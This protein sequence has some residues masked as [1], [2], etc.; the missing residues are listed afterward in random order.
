MKF[1]RVAAGGLA[2]AAALTVSVFLPSEASAADV[3][4]CPLGSFCAWLDSNYSGPMQID[5]VGVDRYIN[6]G[7]YGVSSYWNRSTLEL[8]AVNRDGR[9]R[10]IVSGEQ[11]ARLVDG[12]N[13]NISGIVSRDAGNGSTRC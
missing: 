5:S 3:S 2:A 7:N 1:K 12:W 8:C 13:D 11:T 4:G 10:K 9:I 6:Y